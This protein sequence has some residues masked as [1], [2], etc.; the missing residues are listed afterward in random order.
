MSRISRGNAEEKANRP[1]ARV[2]RSLLAEAPITSQA[3]LAE[4]LGKTQQAVGQYVS[5]KSEPGYDVLIAIADHFHV[6]TDY[7]LGRSIYKTADIRTQAICDSTGL[8]EESVLTLSKCNNHGVVGSQ[9]LD[10]VDDFIY[11]MGSSLASNGYLIFREE[12]AASAAWHQKTAHLSDCEKEKVLED[13]RQ[14][15]AEENERGYHVL[16]HND[17]ASFYLQ[18]FCDNYKRHLVAKYQPEVRENGND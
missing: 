7:L 14:F 12:A 16:P 15:I 10:A 2:L 3:Q 6:S 11:F 17:A 1:F 8:N 4:I 5:G 9:A 13:W 18:M